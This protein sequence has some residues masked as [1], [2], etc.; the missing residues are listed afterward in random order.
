MA[1]VYIHIGDVYITHP[2]GIY[3]C[4][5]HDSTMKFAKFQFVKNVA[6]RKRL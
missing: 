1:Y 5:V 3:R 6:S 2:E 4:Y